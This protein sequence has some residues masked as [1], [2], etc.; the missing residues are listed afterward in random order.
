MRSVLFISLVL[1]SAARAEP[2]RPDAPDWQRLVAI[3]QYLQSDYPAAIDSH[4]PQELEEQKGFAQDALELAQSLGGAAIEFVPLIRSIQARI[5]Q[6]TDP[7]GVKQDCG[8]L[9]ESLVFAGHLSRSPRRPPDLSL[10]ARL[11]ATDCAACHGLE[12]KG[13]VS[14]ASSMNPKPLS[15]FDGER[16]DQLTPFRT[17]N[18]LTFGV[19][20]TAMPAYTVR[21]EDERWALSFYIFTMRQPVCSQRAKRVTLEE[22][23]T[24]SDSE[25]AARYGAAAVP[26][27]RQQPPPV[28]EKQSL[29]NARAGIEA[30]LRE[31]ANGNRTAARQ[32]AL[33]AYLNGIDPVEPVLRV[34]SES[35][36]TRLEQSFQRFRA[37]LEGNRPSAP[38][39]GRELIATIERV[40]R[41]QG[42]SLEEAS[43]FWLALLVII[44]EGFEVT[45]VLAALLAVLKKMQQ[46]RFARVVHAGWILALISGLALFLVGRQILAGARREWVEGIVA[47]L[48]VGMLL[49]AAFWLNARANIRKFMGKL[50]SQMQTALGTGSAVGLFTISFT[51]M[52]R[53][54]FETALFLQGL[55]IDSQRSVV[56]GAL[57]GC[58]ALA[59]LVLFIG[60]VGYR[61]PMKTLFNAS[62]ALLLGTAVILLGKGLHSLQEVGAL[63][64]FPLPLTDVPMLGFYAD[65]YSLLPQLLMGLVPLV[66]I[67]V[68]RN[69]HAPL[70]P[71]P[72]PDS[73]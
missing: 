35:A 44:R 68:R 3:V 24:S 11:Y 43:V 16:M 55:S 29:A 53:E 56:W 1:A 45:V 27:L 65:A 20:G 59:G 66:W 14:I 63:S 70:A 26:C 37:D 62:T 4:N 19:S 6:A 9:V 58:A 72:D 15:F 48:A 25:L 32:A 17:F 42:R 39:R 36:V 22:L 47:L 60:R 57:S 40:S 69:V 50:R 46:E 7:E 30:A 51:A 31:L 41:D 12:G 21:E 2:T 73:R 8:R 54:S 34:R 10:G 33:D 64:V 13:Q 18:A 23:S 52:F 67:A 38:E 61:L 71:L 5:D 49:Y 28:D